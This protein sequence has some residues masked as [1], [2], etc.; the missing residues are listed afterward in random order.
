[1]DTA[2]GFHR[3]L[4]F[5]V[6]I[7]SGDRSRC[8]EKDTEQSNF[9]NIEWNNEFSQIHSLVSKIRNHL[10]R[11]T[12]IRENLSRNVKGEKRF[13]LGAGLSDRLTIFAIDRRGKW[14]GSGRVWLQSGYIS[15]SRAGVR[16][17]GWHWPREQPPCGG[18]TRFSLAR[19]NGACARRVL[20]QPGPRRKGRRGKTQYDPGRPRGN[21][22]FTRRPKN[23]SRL[24]RPRTCSRGW[25]IAIPR[26]PERV[27][28]DAIPWI[29]E[30]ASIPFCARETPG[31]P[32]PPCRWWLDTPRY[33]DSSSFPLF[34]FW[35]V[36][37][38]VICVKTCVSLRVAWLCYETRYV[39]II[40]PRNDIRFL[41]F[42]GLIYDFA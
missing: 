16:D 19:G 41:L 21:D 27:S 40:V 13:D 31:N 29:V 15:V 26:S 2:L 39:S 32:F 34:F 3:A 42:Y 4:D 8:T 38:C 18:S 5:I 35:W 10:A 20:V 24:P 17:V 25:S 28:L 9:L 37:K 23:K 30:S 11:L 1:M 6:Q 14:A 7:S 22:T 36:I 33:V 12:S